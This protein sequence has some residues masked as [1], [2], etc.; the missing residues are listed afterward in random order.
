MKKIIS[1]EKSLVFKFMDHFDDK[2][3]SI[4][5]TKSRDELEKEI[6]EGIIDGAII[7]DNVMGGVYRNIR[8]SKL[9]SNKHV[10]SYVATVELTKQLEDVSKFFTSDSYQLY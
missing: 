8:F 7:G 5:T 3:L 6:L 1:I 4:I 9:H 10:Y 2:I